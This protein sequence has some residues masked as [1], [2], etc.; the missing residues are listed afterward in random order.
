MKSFLLNSEGASLH[1]IRCDLPTQ[2]A[3]VPT[4]F[5]AADIQDLTQQAPIVL[6]DDE[7]QV[8]RLYEVLMARSGLHTLAIPNGDAALEYVLHHPV[9]LVISEL[10]RRHINGLAFLEVLRRTSS[11]QHVPFMIITATP[12]YEARQ[13]FVALSGNAFLTKPIDG[14]QL[15]HIV[16]HTL[17]AQLSPQPTQ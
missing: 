7:P 11:K 17:S 8:T 4:P 6:V 3:I 12:D 2:A 10:H 16:T 14:R 5:A 1:G 13:A 15:T 9:S